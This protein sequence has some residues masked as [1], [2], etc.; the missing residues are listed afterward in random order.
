[1]VPHS[2][3]HHSTCLFGRLGRSSRHTHREDP[4]IVARITAAALDVI[5]VAHREGVIAESRHLVATDTAGIGLV[6]VDAH[7]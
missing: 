5:Y 4:L 7:C 2:V 6:V 3:Q 1:M